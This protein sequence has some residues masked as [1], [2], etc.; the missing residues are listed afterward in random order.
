MKYLL[1][2]FP[3]F[4]FAQS[5]VNKSDLP[6]YIKHDTLIL[7]NVWIKDIKQEAKDR[8]KTLIL[9]KKLNRIEFLMNEKR[10]TSSKLDTLVT[11]LE[12]LQHERDS[13]IKVIDNDLKKESNILLQKIQIL[14]ENI[15]IL[16]GQLKIER[17]KNRKARKRCFIV[18]GVAILE[19]VLIVLLI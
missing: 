14:G 3:F 11:A 18:L 1:L 19:G 8:K 2:L 9:E 5:V 17:H 13:L 12:K 15:A 10:K 16:Q 7:S 6:V 4:T